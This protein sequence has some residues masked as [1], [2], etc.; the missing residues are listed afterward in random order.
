[1]IID[2]QLAGLIRF[3]DRPRK[4][5][6]SF[7]RH[8]MPKHKIKHL[9]ILSGDRDIEVQH[10]AQIVGITDV[11]AS[12]TPEEKL[13]IVCEESAKRSTLFLG[14]G[15]NDAPAAIQRQGQLQQLSS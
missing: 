1:M 8:L 15:N 13:Q 2:G 5:S 14:D 9:M 4:D 11:R 7:I 12:L 10:L 6:R 3:H